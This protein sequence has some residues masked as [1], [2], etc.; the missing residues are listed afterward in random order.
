MLPFKR[1]PR[2]NAVA[3]ILY[4]DVFLVLSDK[5]T[6]DLRLKL[7]RPGN[8]ESLSQQFILECYSLISFIITFTFQRRFIDTGQEKCKKILDMFHTRLFDNMDVPFTEEHKLCDIVEA[9]YAE[10]YPIMKDDLE[11]ARDG[12][13]EILFRGI[14]EAFFSR[15]APEKSISEESLLFGLFIAELY[16]SISDSYDKIKRY[17]IT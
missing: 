4:E 14:P 6:N 16:S 1:G 5:F 7:V 10:Y 12:I 3:D 11:C 2:I 17:K 15:V 9:R 8:S 13:G